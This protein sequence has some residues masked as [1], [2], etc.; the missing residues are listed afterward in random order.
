MAFRLRPAITASTLVLLP[1]LAGGFMLQRRE[2]GDSARLFRQVFARVAR[3]NVDSL[4]PEDMYEK[5][6]RGL[7]KN[8]GDPYADLYSPKELA[9]FTRNSLGNAYGGI[10]VQIEDQQGLFIVAK[11]FPNTPAEAGGVQLGD[12]IAAVD[13]MSTSGKRI[14]DVSGALTGEPGT[15][16]NVTFARPGISQPIVSRFM[17]A[18]VHVPAVPFALML[19]EGIGYVPLQRFN[20]SAADE[21]TRAL[22]HLRAAGARS[23]ILDLRGNGGGSFDQSLEVA[24]LFLQRAQPIVTVRMRSEAPVESRA[25]ETPRIPLSPLIILTDGFTASASEI[26]AGALQ[27]HDRAVLVGTT[28]FGKGLVQTVF[29]LDGG[30]ALKM[31]TGKWYTPSGRSIQRDRVLRDDGRLVEVT[32]DS[33]E[34]DSV[35]RARPQFKSDGGRVVYG[36]G[37]ITPDVIVPADTITTAEQKFVRA[38]GPKSQETYVTLYRFALDLKR[39]AKPDFTVQPAWRDSLFTR[40]RTAGVE[41]PR[42]E[43]DAAKSLVDRMIESRVAT[44]IAGDSSAFRRLLPTDSQLGRAIDMLRS[45]RSQG[46]LLALV[47]RQ[48]R[49]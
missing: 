42:A 45:S 34:T 26:V 44:L 46:E 19:E 25:V 32:P 47:S 33:L 9:S 30:W 3:D 37:G 8:L 10:G 5:A 36:G 31:T 1:A 6:A 39:T 17:R 38:I 28:S 14:E 29:P 21:L 43:F 35:R 23:Y 12:R 18:R 13:V 49:S 27:D 2:Q 15:N 22:E 11:V 4:S 20:D 40:L 41:V 16:V 48:G 24:N 7:V